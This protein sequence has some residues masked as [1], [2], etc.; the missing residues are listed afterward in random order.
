MS[1]NHVH[2]TRNNPIIPQQAMPLIA[3][4]IHVPTQIQAAM[5][6]RLNYSKRKPIDPDET[7]AVDDLGALGN[8]YI[9]RSPGGSLR[10]PI[11]DVTTFFEEVHE[12][13]TKRSRTIDDVFGSMSLRPPDPPGN[14]FHG[15]RFCRGPNQS[16][17]FCDE[18]ALRRKT[19]EP[20]LRDTK[21][22]N[23]HHEKCGQ[24][25]A[26]GTK[27]L[28]INSN[29]NSNFVP[30]QVDPM[31]QCVEQKLIP[32]TATSVHDGSGMS[33]DD[34]DS[35]VSVSE[36]AIR[37]AMY[38][39]VFGRRM[40]PMSC[41]TIGYGYYDAVDSKIEDLIRKSRL[42]AAIKSKQRKQYSLTEM[43]IE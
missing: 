7:G 36:S 19:S 27:M 39:I 10:R 29:E 1:Q 30:R 20:I 34:S 13:E 35:G 42:E 40:S 32:E 24:G 6:G 12:P 26:I 28:Q 16:D 11:S 22:S 43:D 25:D 21:K 9:A 2:I 15:D 5:E 18:N 3:Y 4:Q 8:P 14:H 37:R 33:I 41:D 38:R 31:Q 17:F 23:I